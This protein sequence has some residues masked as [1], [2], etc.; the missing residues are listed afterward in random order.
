MGIVAYIYK[1]DLGD[2]TNGGFSSKVREVCIV[3]AS[4]PFK[5]SD[6]CPA[7]VLESGYNGPFT[8][9]CVRAVSIADKEDGEWLMHGGNFLHTSDSRFGDL[10]EE[11]TGRKNIGPIAIHDRKE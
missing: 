1:S 6:E 5:P 3:N 7:V 9:D 4:G 2:C 10:I 8:N 11:L